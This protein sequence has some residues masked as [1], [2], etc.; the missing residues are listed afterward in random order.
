MAGVSGIYRTTDNIYK[1]NTGRNSSNN[2]NGDVKHII[3]RDGKPVMTEVIRVGNDPEA[4]TENE[5]LT[6]KQTKLKPKK[7][8]SKKFSGR[9]RRSSEEVM[10]E[11]KAKLSEKL[12]LAVRSSHTLWSEKKGIWISYQGSQKFLVKLYT[13]QSQLKSKEIMTQAEILE[14]SIPGLLDASWEKV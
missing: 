11:K 9:P 12:K 3:F 7:D 10:R 4:S 1:V 2:R 5:A 8:Q 13:S 14:S 6:S